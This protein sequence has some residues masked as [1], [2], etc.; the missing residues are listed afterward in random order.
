MSRTA[1]REALGRLRPVDT[2]D[3]IT[4]STEARRVFGRP[5]PANQATIR[6]ALA[7]VNAVPA[8]GNTQ[9][10]KALDQAFASEVEPGRARYVFFMTDG[11]V[12]NEAA[13]MARAQNFVAAMGRRGQRG[14]VFTMGVGSSVNR[15][16]IDGLARAGQGLPVYAT[17]REDPMR[18]V[19]LFF[20]LIDR[21]LLQGVSVNWGGLQVF[22]LSPPVVPDLFASHPL[23]VHGRY[24]GE[25]GAM[26]VTGSVPGQQLTLPV[27]VERLGTRGEPT[28]VLG[29]LWARARVADLLED[30]MAEGSRAAVEQVTQLGLE[31]RLVTPYTSLV[32]VDR[33][34]VV[35][36]GSP[37]TV[38]VPQEQPEGVP[39]DAQSSQGKT[40]PAR[41]PSAPSP[42]TTG[43]S[44]ASAP[45]SKGE[46][47]RAK[48]SVPAGVA[49]WPG[50]APAPG[51]PVAP[52]SP[53]PGLGAPV[54]PASPPA[55]GPADQSAA[56]PAPAMPQSETAK[57]GYPASPAYAP[58][59][60]IVEPKRGCGCRVPG[61]PDRDAHGVTLLLAALLLGGARRRRRA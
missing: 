35:S 12:G 52:A 49:R 53:A 51:A 4:F 7:R 15:H 20:G 59:P 8:R 26:S 42:A 43:E 29:T 41:A 54:P 3:I 13:V 21:P 27:R 33:A 32:A 30:V 57:S 2:F 44:A 17:G 11:Y 39:F 22:D 28:Q 18:A 61:S 55:A 38:L 40:T 34:R 14:R 6:E 60:P 19:N 31:H 10:G 58:P 46:A 5:R 23:I 37:T 36:S 56:Y 45:K 50:S 9:I 47:P 16:L 24:Q 48:S 25:P 1:I